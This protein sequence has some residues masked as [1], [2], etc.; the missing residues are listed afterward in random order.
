MPGDHALLVPKTRDGRGLYVGPRLGKL[1]LGAAGTPRQALPHEP[2][3][4]VEELDFIR[5][6]AAWVL[7]RPVQTADIRRVRFGLRPWAAAPYAPHGATRALS[8]E[9]PI[10]VDGAGQLTVSGGKWAIYLAMDEDVLSRCFDAGL[11]PPR[12]GGHLSLIHI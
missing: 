2:N 9:H 4:F 3:A 12:S 1:I 10:L 7:R 6:E 5:T 8:R 11:L